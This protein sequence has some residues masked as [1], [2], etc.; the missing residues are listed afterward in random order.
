MMLHE[1]EDIGSLILKLALKHFQTTVD[2]T[3]LRITD[4]DN[5]MC[6]A[7]KF[8]HDGKRYKMVYTEAFRDRGKWYPGTGFREQTLILMDT[9]DMDHLIGIEKDGDIWTLK[10]KW[11]RLRE[12]GIT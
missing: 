4:R 7:T 2:Q 6:I 8:F 10:P 1:I 11:G 9:E 12:L 5:T 3:A